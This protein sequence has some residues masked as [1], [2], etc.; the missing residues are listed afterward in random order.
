MAFTK[1]DV[2]YLGGA[3][4]ALQSAIK[5]GFGFADKAQKASL[6]L[7]LTLGSAR[8]RLGNSLDGLKGSID[9]QLTAGLASLEAGLRGNQSGVARLINQQQLTGT[10]F[11]TT[12]K[13]LA[14]LNATVG[15]SNEGTQILA[16]SLVETGA[17]FGVSTDY[18]VQTIQS[19]SPQFADLAA[20]GLENLPGA[21]AEIA[22]SLPKGLQSSLNRIA[23]QIFAVGEEGVALRARLGLQ[24]MFNQLQ[25]SGRT[26]AEIQQI[27]TQQFIQGGQR[28]GQLI[29]G[30]GANEVALGVLKDSIASIGP[31]LMVVS[32]QLQKA[33]REQLDSTTNY[34]NTISTQLA[35]VW[36]PLKRAVMD[37]YTAT[38]P[39]LKS[40]IGFLTDLIE[41]GTFKFKQLYVELGGVD[42]ALKKL[43]NLFVEY[44]TVIFAGLATTITLVVIPALVA[45]GSAILPAVPLFIGVGLAFAGLHAVAKKLG[46]SFGDM[47][48][49]AGLVFKKVGENI[50]FEFAKIFLKLENKLFGAD[51]QVTSM[52]IS[53][54]DSLQKATISGI[55]KKLENLRKE[56]ERLAKEQ[57]KKEEEERRRLEAEYRRQVARDTDLYNNQLAQLEA[58]R[59]ILSNT[60]REA[61]PTFMDQTVLT[62]QESVDRILGV[63]PR[64]TT[65]VFYDMRDLMEQQIGITEEMIFNGVFGASPGS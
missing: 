43:K 57:E 52:L 62:L 12:A 55:D 44:E 33:S 14:Q 23:S 2:L 20:L 11:A 15:L 40:G 39:L 42:G 61:T 8:E 27:L 45:I 31:D 56:N 18:L 13:T 3:L 46:F 50:K 35:Q 24:N 65:E 34:G 30:V 64:D 54:L 17:K 41:D 28:F 29:G 37:L 59:G 22:A 21:F 51:E 32:E 7:G 38:F 25:N 9:Q 53:T 5:D 63:R 4:Y 47:A 10:S 49:D 58:Q 1:E 60:A 19:L 6:S 36:N 16:D 48:V 26:Q